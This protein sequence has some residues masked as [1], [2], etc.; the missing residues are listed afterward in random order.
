MT[1]ITDEIRNSI[2]YVRNATIEKHGYL[3]YAEFLDDFLSLVQNM[4]KTKHDVHVDRD[5]IALRYV[6]RSSDFVVEIQALRQA[7]QSGQ[8]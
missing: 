5:S 6:Y 4:I 7:G 1:G 8:V 2:T 3:I